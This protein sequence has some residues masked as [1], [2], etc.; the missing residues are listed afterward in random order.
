MKKVLVIGSSGL[1]GSRFTG[2]YSDSF[3]L[4]TPDLNVLDITDRNSVEKFFSANNLDTVINFAAFTDVKKA[5][6]ERE[7]REGEAWKVNV[8]GVN[9][10][11]EECNK[12]DIFLIHISTDLVFECTEKSAQ[13][14]F[15]NTILPS[16]P[17]KLC[18]YG[19]TKLEAENSIIKGSKNY[20]IIRIA[21]PY[22]A[23]Y[24]LKRD[25]AN[26]FITMFREGTL[27]P[28]FTDN[29]ITPT[30]IDEFCTALNKVVEDKIYGIFHIV[31]NNETSHFEFAKY[32]LSKLGYDVTHVKT[33]LM[34]EFIKKSSMPRAIYCYLDSKLTQKALKMKFSNWQKSVD[35]LVSQ[36]KN[37]ESG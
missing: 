20:T 5:E 3:E 13:R 30:F 15:E 1:V 8:E 31:S 35:E 32:L 23:K 29:I 2:L 25:F 6:L 22:R 18:W 28:L 7:N 17:L 9:N 27:Y 34:L 26:T 10:L 4:L 11:V 24:E 14:I 36:I 19:W 12:K 37:L 33:Q 16:N 21:Y